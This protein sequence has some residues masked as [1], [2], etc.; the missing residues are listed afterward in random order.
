MTSLLDRPTFWRA[1]SHF[2]RFSVEGADTATLLHHLSTNHIKKLKDGEGCDAILISSKARVLDWLTIWR[3]SGKFKVLTSPNRSA[4]FVPHAQRFVL[5]RQEV[6][7][8]NVS[9]HGA[10][11]GLF[12]AEV[13]AVLRQWNAEAILDAPVNNRISCDV[14]GVPL[15]L[16]QTRRLPGGGVLVESENAAALQR[17]IEKTEIPLCDDETYNTQRV[18]AGLP[19]TG[20]ELTEDVN[21][22]E[23][24]LDFAISLDKGCYNGQE[25][26][27]R[28]N[29][30]KKVKQGLFGLKLQNPLEMQVVTASKVLLK[31]NGRDAGFLTSSAD[32]SRFGSIG[33]AYIR[34][35][36]Q[37]PGQELEVLSTPPQTATVSLLPF[38]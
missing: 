12:G 28:L 4:M 10:L 13:P 38:S 7:F 19:A 2:G 26:I 21:P 14:E 20:L 16:S 1:M 34:N 31:S 32:S 27:A 30:Y 24:D 11:W 33:L 36:F 22:W 17:L 5:Y 37:Q 9:N 29:T 23:A 15:W 35:D 8:N 3:E 18:E 6:R 25:I